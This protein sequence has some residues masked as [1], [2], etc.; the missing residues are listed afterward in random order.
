MSNTSLHTTNLVAVSRPRRLI[1]FNETCRRVGR[2]RWW[3]RDAVAAGYFPKPVT[4]GN[5]AVMFVEH[6]IDGWIEGLIEQ[7]DQGAA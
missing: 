3:V 2:S 4:Y 7:R 1:G 6:E 5:R